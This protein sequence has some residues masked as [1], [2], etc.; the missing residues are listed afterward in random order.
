[1]AVPDL[2]DHDLD[3]LICQ[4]FMDTILKVNHTLFITSDEAD[5]S[6]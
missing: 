2:L 4:R 3:A 1:M 6:W 5:F